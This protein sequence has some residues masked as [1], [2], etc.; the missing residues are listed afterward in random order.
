MSRWRI[1]VIMVGFLAP[2]LALIG[3]GSYYL[4]RIGLSF[5]LWWPMAASLVLS[6]FLAWYWQRKKVLLKPVDFTPPMQWTERDL[7]AWKLVEA[8]AQAADKIG[9]DRLSEIQFYVSTAQEMALELARFYH[10]GANDPFGSLTIPELLAVVELVAHDLSLMVD[11]YVPGSHLLTINNWRRAKQATEWYDVFNKVYWA[12]SAIFTPIRTGLRFA[13]THAGMTTPWRMLQENLIL[14][15]YTAYVHELGTYLIDLNSGRLRVGAHRYRELLTAVREPAPVTEGT[16]TPAADPAEKV[17]QVTLTVMGQVKAGKSS[18]INALLGEQRAVTDVLPMTADITRYELKP[19]QV[20]TRLVLLDTVGYAHEGPKEDQLRATEE[21]A[22]ESDLLLLVLHARNPAR[23]ADVQMLQ[24]LR[25]WFGSKPELKMPPVLVVLTHI[26]LLSPAME[27]A[28]PY[29]WQDPQRLKEKNIREA[30][31][32][33]KEQL[34]GSV[35][36]VIPACTA[37]GKV[38]GIEEFLL[39]AVMEL[40]DEAHAVAVL[41]CLRA[42]ADAGKVRKVFEQLVQL[43]KQAALVFLQTYKP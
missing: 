40:L 14:W 11:Q 29:R 19:A 16:P 37:S 24:S 33:V 28:P 7:Q 12:V 34:G 9:P 23:L 10:P 42:E 30:W 25:Q 35:V 5:W 43:G 31:E 4:W 36:G 32:A 27:W 2:I 15:F 26:D 8:R 18:L 39:P 1:I 17:R 22:R 13:A 41:R 3:L 20:P 21:A 6:Y 38:Y